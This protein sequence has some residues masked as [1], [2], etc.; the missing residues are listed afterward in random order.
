M[1]FVLYAKVRRE[2]FKNVLRHFNMFQCSVWQSKC[3]RCLNRCPQFKLSTRPFFS[4]SYP[5]C[6][7]FS[8]L[9]VPPVLFW[10]QWTNAVVPT[11]APCHVTTFLLWQATSDFVLVRINPLKCLELL[12]WRIFPNGPVHT[13][14]REPPGNSVTIDF[15]K[16]V[17]LLLFLAYAHS[18]KLNKNNKTKTQ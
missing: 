13:S 18:Y 1:F 4:A 2:N 5:F 12:M 15:L 7:C 14:L 17:I 11:K 6:K 3:N 8:R 16:S 10:H 9:N